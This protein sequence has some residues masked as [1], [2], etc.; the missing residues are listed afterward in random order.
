MTRF[1]QT[2]KKQLNNKNRYR[3]K[4]SVPRVIFLE[5]EKIER[6]KWFSILRIDYKNQNFGG[7]VDNFL[8][9]VNHFW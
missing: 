9:V 8:N 6:F 7:A 5:E 4:T 2:E 1:W 3:N